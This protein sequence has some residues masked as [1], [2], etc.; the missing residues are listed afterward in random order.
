MKHITRNKKNFS[1]FHVLCSPPAPRLWRAG[2]FHDKG[3]TIIELMVVITILVILLAMSV[4]SVVLLVKNPPVN[5]ASEEVINALKLAQN[6]TLSSEGN[7]QYGVY[8]NTTADPHQ[9]TIFKGSSYAS[10]TSSFD[11][12]YPLSNTIEFYAINLGGGNEVVFNRITGTT[13]NPGDIS[14]RLKDDHSQTKTIYIDAFGNSSFNNSS[15][16]SDS[17]RVKDSRHV[18]FTYSRVIN[19]ATENII[20][21]FN[22]STTVTIPM[23]SYLNNGQFE[24]TGTTSVAGSNQTIT[25]HTLRLNNSDTQFSVFR[26]MRFNNKTLTIQ[27]SADNTGTLAEYTANGSATDHHSIYVGN[28]TWQ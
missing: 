5:N 9:Y 1:L 19:T 24:W 7:S 21:T 13:Q 28:F 23:S 8:F 27:L 26:D 15:A 20:L 11:Q 25:I 2:M 16:A 22:G 6:R 4:A 12:T 14:L 10:R 3:F 17:A 18:D